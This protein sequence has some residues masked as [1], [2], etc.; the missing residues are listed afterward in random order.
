VK[1][2]SFQGDITL[3]TIPKPFRGHNAVIQNNAIRSWMALRPKPEIFLLGRDEGVK[4]TARE[5]GVIHLPDIECNEYG[6]PLI[7]SIFTAA[8]KAAS[9][10][11][12][13]YINADIILLSD[14]L[15]S[16]RMVN[17]S[18]FLVVGRRWDLDV[19]ETLD[20]TRADLEKDL[21]SHVAAKGQ[22]HGISGIDYF[23]FPKGLYQDIPPFAVGRTAWDNWFIYRA[24]ALKASVIDATPAITIIHQNHDY[25]HTAGGTAGV[26]KGP[27]SEKNKALLGSPDHAFSLEYVTHL[28]TPGGLKPALTPR[29]LYFRLEA[30]PVLHPKL[31]FLSK[32]MKSLTGLLGSIRSKL[33][34]AS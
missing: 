5:L 17:K 6:T 20:F 8:G 16:L 31:H 25:S 27:E 33:G 24:R 32:P 28:L 34:I 14:F 13:C 21:R 22:L 26:W 9:R 10:N 7:S 15:A 12:I 1:N 23:V 2:S 11:T 19:E 4:E 3:F 18:N 30:V 29:S